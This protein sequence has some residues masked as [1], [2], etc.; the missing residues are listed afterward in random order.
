LHQGG[1]DL[2]TAV[3]FLDAGFLINEGARSLGWDRGQA[4]PEAGAGV[5]AFRS[6]ASAHGWELLRV[7]WYDGAFDPGDPRANSQRVYHEAIAATSGV[8]IRLGHLQERA[9]RWQHALRKAIEDCGWDLA[10]LEKRFE[11]RPQLEQKG[12]D[13][14][15]ALDLVKLAQG[16]VYDAAL[17]FSGDRDLAEAV[18]VVQDEGRR[19][20]L[21]HPVGAGVATELR[22]LADEVVVLPKS[23][24]S[25]GTMCGLEKMLRQR[26]RVTRRPT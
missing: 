26:A 21:L 12:V 5:S 1:G 13:T 9:P 23:A 8:Q 6:I 2:P 25:D 19:V 16:R 14:L 4:Q 11:F 7:Y 17:L 10:Q 22:H 24:P 15:I 20:L 18:R 3:G